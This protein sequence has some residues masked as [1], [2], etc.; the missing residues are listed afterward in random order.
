MTLAQLSV[1]QDASIKDL[2][3]SSSLQS[4]DANANGP[5]NKKL[6]ARRNMGTENSSAELLLEA[7]VVETHQR[8]K[9]YETSDIKKDPF[10]KQN[11]TV[12]DYE[13]SELEEDR[14]LSSKV[15]SHSEE[16]ISQK[17]KTQHSPNNTRRNNKK[18]LN[19]GENLN[20]KNNSKE[21]P[22]KEHPGQSNLSRSDNKKGGKDGKRHDEE[23]VTTKPLTRKSKEE[24]DNAGEKD[25]TGGPL[26]HG[27]SFHSGRWGMSIL[28]PPMG[29]LK[30]ISRRSM[31]RKNKEHIEGEKD[32]GHDLV[33]GRWGM[34]VSSPPKEFLEDTLIHRGSGTGH[35]T[36]KT[37]PRPSQ[38]KE[39]SNRRSLAHQDRQNSQADLTQR[40]MIDER[41][42]ELAETLYKKLANDLYAFRYPKLNY[43]NNYRTNVDLLNNRPFPRN[44]KFLIQALQSYIEQND[45]PDIPIFCRIQ[46]PYAPF[47]I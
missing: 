13:R 40:L 19:G 3:N 18:Y 4:T 42:K 34:S 46:I 21:S 24:R 8:Y 6:K 9:D 12:A 30:D 2:R 10:D 26:N 15:N 43:W 33:G 25:T 1:D 16:S 31:H 22:A 44:V 5:F 32:G 28:S 36:V 41:N 38:V 27:E 29:F 11:A 47:R 45:I 37:G 20:Y 14:S 17:S 35:S 23:I 39:S 7:P